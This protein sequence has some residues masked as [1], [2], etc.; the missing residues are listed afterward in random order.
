ML[1]MD[2]PK[3]RADEG[4]Q[5]VLE[6]FASQ[7]INQPHRRRVEEQ[8]EKVEDGRIRACQAIQDPIGQ[9]LQGTIKIVVLS[10]TSK[11]PHRT[12]EDARPKMG[13]RYEGVLEDLRDIVEDK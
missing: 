12:H 5:M 6:Q 13:I 10:R 11:R 1:G 4:G 3:Q 9:E 8:M 7:S 2:R